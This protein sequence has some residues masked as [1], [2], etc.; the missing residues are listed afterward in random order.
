MTLFVDCYS[1][2]LGKMSLDWYSIPLLFFTWLIV[3]LIQ[4]DLVVFSNTQPT[5]QQEII[6]PQHSGFTDFNF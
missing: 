3:E 2:Q 6:V 5:E 1:F 4:A